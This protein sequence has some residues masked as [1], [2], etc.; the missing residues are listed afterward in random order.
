MSTTVLRE[1][2]ASLVPGKRNTGG[3]AGSKEMVPGQS[4]DQL[5]GKRNYS[6]VWKQATASMREVERE[7]PSH[8]VY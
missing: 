7:W 1:R 4:W 6:N 8:L 3:K 2:D 5:R